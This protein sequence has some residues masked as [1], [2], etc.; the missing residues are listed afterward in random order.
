[1]AR[2]RGAIDT[3]VLPAEVRTDHS[4]STRRQFL[5]AAAAT[6]AATTIGGSNAVAE[7]PAVKTFTHGEFSIAILSDGH[8]TVP[9][10]FLARNASE[11]DIRTSIGLP[12]NHVTPPCN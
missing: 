11:A 2:M 12:F 10:R 6:L 1:M 3:S 5:N 4:Q 8:L 9:T 7:T